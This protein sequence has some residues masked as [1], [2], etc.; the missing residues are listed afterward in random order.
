MRWQLKAALQKT[1]SA[2]PRGEAANYW[3]QRHVTG[4]LPRPD[5]SFEHHVEVALQ[6][7][8]AFERHQDLP[9]GEAAFY[10]FG[11]GWDLIG[12]LTYWACGVERQVL[13]D[14]RPNFRP[15][16]VEDA[17]R[18]LDA[19]LAD[20]GRTHRPLG[21]AGIRSTADLGRFGI[22]YRAPCDARDT[23]LPA[24]S[25]D[26]ISSTFTMEHIPAAD[27]APILTECARL[28]RPGATISSAID[29]QDHY[30]YGDPRIGPHNYLRFSDRTWRLVNSDLHYQNRL[31]LPQ[32]RALIEDSGL[33][34][35]EEDPLPAS[36]G[37]RDT[38]AR[39]ELAPRFAG[40]YSL[41]DLTAL[42]AVFV[43][44][45]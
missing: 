43:A 2:L 17:L 36:E 40:R 35:V 15:E 45:R 7:L 25:F 29:F 18:R 23:G 21:A 6:H 9:L 41:D 10:E 44:R 14:I 12:P 37:D 31:R 30:S 19:A 3:M 33:E 27:L 11:A 13:V 22:E 38:A 4:N 5:G 24:A 16:L 34:I 26:F 20:C 42:G 39:M 32:Y 28:L 1:L 8:A